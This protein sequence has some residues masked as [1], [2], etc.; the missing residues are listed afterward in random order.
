MFNWHKKGLIFTPNKSVFWQKSHAALPTRLFLGGNNYRI[1]FTSRDSQNKTYVG[2]FEIDLKEPEKIVRI[3]NKPVLSP[4]PLGYFDDHGVQACSIV[5]ADNGDLYLYYLGWNPGLRKP[6]FYTSIGLAISKDGGETFSKYSKAPILQR[7][8]FDP[9]MVSGGTV[10]RD[11]NVWR[12][13]YLSGFKFEMHEDSAIS[14]YDIKYAESDDGIHW[15]RSGHIVLPLEKN[16]SNISRMSIVNVGDTFYAFYPVKKFEEGYRMGFAN[17]KDG[18]N[19]TRHDE[20]A[21]LS[22]SNSGFDSDALDKMEVIFHKG[23]F[24]L[25]YNGN[26][27]GYDGIGLAT[28]VKYEE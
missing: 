26:N 25:F 27:F 18:I 20:K 17:S 13:Y 4:G 9:W 16:E 21:G 24:Y 1:Y 3:S 28:C 7:S 15:E 6:L 22:V 23:Q 5:R 19:W 12:M 10:I 14:Y 11:D 8:E 2:Y